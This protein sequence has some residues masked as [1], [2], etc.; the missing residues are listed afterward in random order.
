M[1]YI[2]KMMLAL[3]AS[4]T[5]AIPAD[6]WDFGASGSMSTTFNQTTVKKN[7]DDKAKTSM[8]FGSDAGEIALSSSHSEGDSTVTI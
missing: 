7:S 3:L 1:K 4:V 2:A 6:A 5:L 8:G